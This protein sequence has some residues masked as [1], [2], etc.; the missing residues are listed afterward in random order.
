MEQKTEKQKEQRLKNL[1]SFCSSEFKAAIVSL[2]DEIPCS[3]EMIGCYWFIPEPYLTQY[4]TELLQAKQ[5]VEIDSLLCAIT[6]E[7]VP[8][9]ISEKLY[10]SLKSVSDE[11]Q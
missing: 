3:K 2:L 1:L 7:K 4:I 11:K 5:I 9:Y 8:F 10:N 6:G